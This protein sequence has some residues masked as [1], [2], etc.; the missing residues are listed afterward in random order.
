MFGCFASASDQA[1]NDAII[2]A[3]T[4]HATLLEL[5]NDGRMIV[6]QSHIQVA[7]AVIPG[8]A[9]EADNNKIF[10]SSSGSGTT[11][12]FIGNAQIQVSS[13][14]RLKTNIRDTEM[15]PIET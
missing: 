7:G 3:R 14:K 9:S 4:N 13:D 2:R 1:S 15:N 6:H 8:T 10:T 12:M 11:P 5:M